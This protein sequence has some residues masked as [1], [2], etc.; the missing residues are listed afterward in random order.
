MT[1][2]FAAV[3][4]EPDLVEYLSS[5]L[6]EQTIENI[7]ALAARSGDGIY[8]HDAITTS[9]LISIEIYG[10]IPQQFAF[11]SGYNIV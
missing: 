6:L 9:D 1:N 3:R 11:G 10:S 7:R 8:I 4:E 5:K 2:L